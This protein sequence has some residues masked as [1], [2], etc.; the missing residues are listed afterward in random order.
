[1]REEVNLVLVVQRKPG[2]VDF[3]R[4]ALALEPKNVNAMDT[5]AT[6]LASDGQD[7]EALVLQKTAVEAAPNVHVLKLGLARLAIKTK[8]FK[9]AHAKLDELSALGKKFPAQSEVWQLRQQ[10]P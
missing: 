3:A 9:L 2:A 1:M 7:A 10:L 8:D 5:L 4:R 6:A